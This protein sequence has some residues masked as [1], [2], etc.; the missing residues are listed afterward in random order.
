MILKKRLS[1]SNMS[2]SWGDVLAQQIGHWPLEKST[3]NW[4]CPQDELRNSLRYAVYY[5]V[6]PFLLRCCI[7][8][9]LKA[10]LE[11]LLWAL[12]AL[13][14]FRKKDLEAMLEDK[15]TEE[16]QE[17]G[18][19]EGSGLKFPFHMFPIWMRRFHVEVRF[20]KHGRVGAW[21]PAK[22]TAWGVCGTR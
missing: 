10:I 13:G 7:Y 15:D 21:R 3:V 20:I 1:Q 8:K 4:G 17:L 22:V 6:C 14:Q 12:F 19:Q 2:L 16:T 9:P 5:T 11:K 18:A